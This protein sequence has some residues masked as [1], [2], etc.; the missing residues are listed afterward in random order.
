M[1]KIKVNGD[2]GKFIIR[3]RKRTNIYFPYEIVAN[4]FQTVTTTIDEAINYLIGRFGSKVIYEVK[5]DK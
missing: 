2:Y 5:I 3:K 1:E 4:N